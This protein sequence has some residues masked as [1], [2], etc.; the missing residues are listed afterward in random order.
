MCDIPYKF[1][2]RCLQLGKYRK[3]ITYTV[4]LWHLS[5]IGQTLLH[6]ATNYSMALNKRRKTKNKYIQ[7]QIALL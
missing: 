2:C 4:R 3:L 6:E 1:H 5:I 7:E